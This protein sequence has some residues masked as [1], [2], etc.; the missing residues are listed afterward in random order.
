MPKRRAHSGLRRRSSERAGLRDSKSVTNA[1]CSHHRPAR[2]PYGT[3]QGM[4]YS[5]TKLARLRS[6][7]DSLRL[8]EQDARTELAKPETQPWIREQLQRLISRL[9][10][11]SAA[12]EMALRKS[13]YHD[14]A[15]S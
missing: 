10:E 3:I 9:T 6:H 5:D 12:S 8:Q 14:R 2:K 15:A 11:E 13:D 4:S 7:V 1:M